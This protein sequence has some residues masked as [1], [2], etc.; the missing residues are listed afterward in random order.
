MSG[1]SLHS[2]RC[3]LVGIYTCALVSNSTHYHALIIKQIPK[4]T[5]GVIIIIRHI[6]V[7]VPLWE[8]VTYKDSQ[9]PMFSQNQM[10]VMDSGQSTSTK[11]SSIMTTFHTHLGWYCLL[12]MQFSLKISQDVYQMHMDQIRELSKSYRH[13]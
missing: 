9:A 3:H 11:Q 1:Q 2:S 8:E 13:T 12:E 5:S 4:S 10:F 7:T 6:H